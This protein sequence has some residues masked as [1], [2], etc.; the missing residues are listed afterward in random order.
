MV[1]SGWASSTSGRMSLEAPQRQLAWECSQT[2]MAQAASLLPQMEVRY[3]GCLQHKLLL[4][5]E[6]HT[7]SNR[8]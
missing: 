3:L 2:Y 1:S 4:C 7:H 8:I 5:R 6:L